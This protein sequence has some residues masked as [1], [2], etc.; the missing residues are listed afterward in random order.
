MIQVLSHIYQLVQKSSILHVLIYLKDSFLTSYTTSH[1]QLNPFV[2]ICVMQSSILTKYLHHCLITI[3][4]P[5]PPVSSFSIHHIQNAFCQNIVKIS[6][7]MILE[8]YYATKFA[9]NLV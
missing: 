4:F 6:S 7:N 1:Q 9:N 8:L 2:Y 5:I 3:P